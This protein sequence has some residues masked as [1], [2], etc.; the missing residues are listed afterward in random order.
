MS[1]EQI[2]VVLIFYVIVSTSIGA[3]VGSWRG[4]P[5]AGLFLGFVAGP[6]GWLIVVAAPTAA[7]LCAECHHPTTSDA[8]VCGACGRRFS[9]PNHL[10]AYR[11]VVE[12]PAP[13]SAGG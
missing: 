11:A 12:D 7:P 6:I 5:G 8:K 9:P 10:S 4:R 2:L 3:W 13:R 1:N